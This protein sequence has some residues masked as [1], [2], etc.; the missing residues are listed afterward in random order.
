MKKKMVIL[1]AVF[2]QF[3]SEATVPVTGTASSAPVAAYGSIYT[4]RRGET[5]FGSRCR[6]ATE[7]KF[8]ADFDGTIFSKE[9]FGELKNLEK[10][11]IP[12]SVKTINEKCFKDCKKL[13]KVRF[14]PNSGLKTVGA[15][16][17]EKLPLESIE[18]PSSV[19]TIGTGSFF[20]CGNLVKVTFADGSRLGN[21]GVHAFYRTPIASIVITK[22]VTE[23]AEGCFGC[24]AKLAAV[25]FEERSESAKEL[26]VKSG[27]FEYCT[28]LGEI[29][30]TKIAVF[31]EDGCFSR[32]TQLRTVNLHG[33]EPVK[34][35][36]GAF[37]NCTSLVELYLPLGCKA[38][39]LPEWLGAYFCPE[40]IRIA[41]NG[42][43]LKAFDG[44]SVILHENSPIDAID[45]DAFEQETVENVVLTPGCGIKRIKWSAFE[46]CAELKR[47]DLPDS[48]NE[49]EDWAFGY[50]YSLEEINIPASVLEIS[51][52]S[53]EFCTRLRKITFGNNSRLGRIGCG[54]FR[55]CT[56]LQQ[57]NVPDS[58]WIIDAGS[59][60]DC[61]ELRKVIFGTKPT[62]AEIAGSAFGG[63][64]SLERINIPASVQ[65]IGSCC[66]IECTGLR[67]IT[68][69]TDSNLEQVGQGA[70]RGC[71]SLEKKNVPEKIKKFGYIF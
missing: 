34:I 65:S 9:M 71:S 50:C 32:C 36:A 64:S 47:I 52:D 22:N 61:T 48:I 45:R 35:S 1:G 14:A 27:A 13:K 54:A 6:D 33:A 29:I 58:V 40:N 62:L 41:R 69:G 23:L 68:L 70:F 55:M 3:I 7:L 44:L 53:F 12:A 57:I 38:I 15:H 39:S 31:L 42:E 5:N 4:V 67:E 24:C 16:A 56:S 63:C 21:I 17:F 19:E 46:R 49:I 28:S 25:T 30:F 66:F 51:N 59:F 2:L 8:A 20:E 10:I 18:I 60:V 43:S 26:M 11:T 37:R